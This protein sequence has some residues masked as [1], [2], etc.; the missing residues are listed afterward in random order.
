MQRYLVSA[1]YSDWVEAKDGQEAIDKMTD[2]LI[3]EIKIR[4]F[5]I[6]VEDEDNGQ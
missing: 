6:A 3:K 4:E 2:F 5:E 1:Y